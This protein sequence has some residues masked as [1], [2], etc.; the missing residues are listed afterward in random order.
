MAYRSLT[1]ATIISVI[2]N[3]VSPV[4]ITL[5]SAL[6]AFFRAVM[7]VAAPY[8]WRS[9]HEIGVAAFRQIADLK[10]V[11][12]ESY[13]THGLSLAHRWRAC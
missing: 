8:A 13:D 9:A 11:Y 5:Y 3:Y 4:F 1:F 7:L 12:R 6:D 10:P 2:A